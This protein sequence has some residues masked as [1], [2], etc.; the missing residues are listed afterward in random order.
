MLMI[1]G[2]YAQNDERYSESSRGSQCTAM[3]AAE[4]CIGYVKDPGMWNASD[5]DQCLDIGDEMYRMSIVT[6]RE[7]GEYL[8]RHLRPAE[9]LDRSCLNHNIRVSEL[10]AGKMFKTHSDRRGQLKKDVEVRWLLVL[11]TNVLV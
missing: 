5:V 3:A 6:L 11:R 9:L 4:V 1:Q 10:Q 7:K 8:H 2:H